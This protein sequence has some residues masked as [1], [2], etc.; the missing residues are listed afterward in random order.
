MQS[1]HH[2]GPIEIGLTA[3]LND[4]GQSYIV[5][6]DGTLF[7]ED[8]AMIFIRNVVALTSHGKS[9]KAS[10]VTIRRS[11]AMDEANV[12]ASVFVPIKVCRMRD[13]R[14]QQNQ[15]DSKLRRLNSATCH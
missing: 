14:C 5:D 8:C 2:G 15:S 7:K 12:G 11:K 6:F 13:R 1:P 4:V 10:F 3:L 9:W